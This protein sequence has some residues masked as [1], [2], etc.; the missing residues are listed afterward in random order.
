MR[1]KFIVVILTA[2][3]AMAAVVSVAT[4]SSARTAA[5]ASLKPVHTKI[6]AGTKPSFKYGFAHL[7]RGS[8][9]YLQRQFGSAHVWK[10]VVR[11]YGRSGTA[12]APKLAIGR[13]VYRMHVTKNR[14]TV[15]NSRTHPIYSY[16][17]ISLTALC[18][19]M[20][21]ADC[22]SGTEQVGSTIFSYVMLVSGDVYPSYY[23]AATTSRTSCRSVKL[24]FAND[25]SPD[26]ATSYLKIVQ[27]RTDPQY[28][29]T[30][31]GT[32][33]SFSAHLDGGPFYIDAAGSNGYGSYLAGSASCYTMD[34]HR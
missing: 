26:T 22:E 28:A 5:T 33:G 25:A 15:V 34:G 18:G 6:T 17:K 30:G 31:P 29:Q 10:N 4:P 19:G 1:R 3:A 13:Y 27:S 24:R 2:A 32:V 9:R 8:V 11:V 23:Q 21:S 12:T 14:I 20:D 7:P 16:G